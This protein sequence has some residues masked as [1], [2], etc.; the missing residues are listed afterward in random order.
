VGNREGRKQWLK[1][2]KEN[3]WLKDAMSRL[4]DADASM[5]YQMCWKS[6]QIKN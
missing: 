6:I 5:S 4:E 3:Q 2:D 1:N